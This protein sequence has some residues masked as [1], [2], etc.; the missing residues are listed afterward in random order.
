MTVRQDLAL[1]NGRLGSSYTRGAGKVARLAF[2]Q[3]GSWRDADVERYISQIAPTLSGV[4]LKAAKSTVA[5]YKAMADLTNQDFTQPV[6]T[7][8]DLTTKEL[9]NGA[10]TSLVY[11]RPFVDLRTALSQGKTMTE[12]IEAGAKRA[13]S[14][15]STEVQLARRNA[16]LKARNSN[17]RIV[18]YIRTLTG[19]ENC[20]LC[21]VASTQRYTRGELMPIHPG[22]DC[23][24]MPI[25]GTQDP[26]QVINE[27]RLEAIHE[28]VETRFGV[29]ARDARTLDYRAIK[30]S[31]HGELGPV[32][33]V[34]GDNFTDF[35]NLKLTD[36]KT[37][38]SIK[39][40]TND[41][42]NLQQQIDS[43]YDP[44]AN[45]YENGNVPMRALL[46]Q[47]GKNGVPEIVDTV[48]DLEGEKI[49][50]RG[51][52]NENVD[53]FMNNERHRIGLGIHG[54][55]YYFSTDK[56]TAD[57]FA[58]P[59]QGQ[60]SVKGQVMTGALKPDAKIFNYSGRIEDSDVAR[61]A[62]K[63]IL[64]SFSSYIGSERTENEEFVLDNFALMYQ[65]ALTTDLIVQGYDGMLL[66]GVGQY[67]DEEYLVMFD[68]SKMQIVKDTDDPNVNS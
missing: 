13:E 10:G 64:D 24:E 5:F 59:G 50:Y 42:Q 35:D 8:S 39:D 18:G 25:Y 33:T 67:E 68:R 7:A 47:Q 21:Y 55:G 26:G 22:C 58:I 4:K 46:E 28:N 27:A 44:K 63:N 15:A 40:V 52:T 1:A 9:R 14:L 60:G 20:G 29:S 48:D 49:F 65:D 2:E 12:A 38:N 30:I 61:Q 11:N 34:R 17:D 62:Q 53:A 6:I 19:Q 23:G 66:K 31:E 43:I 36:T 37:Y 32:L 16:G 54:D 51:T 57:S 3:L 56:R 41:A 45:R